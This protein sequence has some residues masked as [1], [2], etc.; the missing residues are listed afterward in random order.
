MATKPKAA[1]PVVPTP[2]APLPLSPPPLMPPPPPRLF[3]PPP[4]PPPS[5]PKPPPP[6]PHPPPPLPP[7]PPPPPS[8]PSTI[9]TELSS[10]LEALDDVARFGLRRWTVD[11]SE[12]LPPALHN[13][14]LPDAHTIHIAEPLLALA[15]ATA[16][17]LFACIVCIVCLVRGCSYRRIKRA[18]KRLMED[19]ASAAVELREVAEGGGKNGHLRT[20]PGG[21]WGGRVD[22]GRRSDSLGTR[23]GASPL[24]ERLE[25]VLAE[26]ER[27]LNDKPSTR[28]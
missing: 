22:S 1:G 18:H 2:A 9:F 26:A 20:P 5:P 10:A 3:P 19:A 21:P 28:W 13:L 17:G 27:V 6:P 15:A 4:L 7:P 14:S 23:T 25:S 8:Q 24:E 11:H 12:D 16:A